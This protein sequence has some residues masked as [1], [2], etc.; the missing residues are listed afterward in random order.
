MKMFSKKTN[1]RT[2]E[3]SILNNAL[4]RVVNA[5]VLIF[6]IM[7]TISVENSPS[8]VGLKIAL[9]LSGTILYLIC[10]K[11]TFRKTK[12]L[13]WDYTERQKKKRFT[14]TYSF[15][16]I[17]LTV[18]LCL[19]VKNICDFHPWT[20]W[21]TEGIV[22]VCIIPFVILFNIL[23]IK[24]LFFPV[25]EDELEIPYKIQKK[26]DNWRDDGKETNNDD[27]IREIIWRDFGIWNN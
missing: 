11:I 6:C 15:I 8:A 1:Q 24:S 27:E 2:M 10:F 23:N 13:E 22:I 4:A 18:M 14:Y 9:I 19:S 3:N 26:P 20:E 21:K 7:M 5:A 12:F 25:F 16:C 17:I